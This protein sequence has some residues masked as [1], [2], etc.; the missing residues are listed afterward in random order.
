MKMEYRNQPSRIAIAVKGL[1][2]WLIII[3]AE[4]GHGIIRGQFLVPLVGE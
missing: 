1:A 4:I 2:I 3:V